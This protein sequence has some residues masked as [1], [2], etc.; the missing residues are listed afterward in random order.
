MTMS[1]T[2]QIAKRVAV[3]ATG[4]KD[5]DFVVEHVAER[6]LEDDENVADVAGSA[7]AEDATSIY[8][9]IG[10]FLV[11]NGYSAAGAAGVCGCIAGE[12]DGDPE[13]VQFPNDPE[14]G[15]A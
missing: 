5:K 4:G 9:A 10:L 1:T 7:V 8:D 3:K 13:A 14:S 2:Q 15:G 11:Q 12:S 6:V